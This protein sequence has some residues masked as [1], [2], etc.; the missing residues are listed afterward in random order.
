[1]ARTKKKPD[2]SGGVNIARSTV[3]VKGSV[4]GRDYKQTFIYINRTRGHDELQTLYDGRVQS[5][6]GYY[7]YLGAKDHPAPF[8]GRAADLDALDEWLHAKNAPPYALLVAPAGR[9]KSALL[10][11]WI[12]RISS[13]LS[14]KKS[15]VEIV[16]FPISSRFNTNLE[17]VVFASLA[18]RLA[19]LYGEKVTTTK[20]AW[21]YRGVFS[22]YLQRTPPK[23]KRIL[24]VVDGLDEAAGWEA[25]ADLFPTV[26][27]NHL[28][29]VVAARPLA[30]D[31]DEGAWLSR[32]GWNTPGKAKRLQ[33]TPLNLD[34]VRDVFMQMGDQLK[35]LK[36]KI[37]LARRLYELSQGDPLLVRLYIEALLPDNG[38]PPTFTLEDLSKQ[39]EREESVPGLKDYFDRWFEKIWGEAGEQDEAILDLFNLCAAAFG[40]LKKSDVLKLAPDKFNNRQKLE[41]A[42]HTVRRFII[43]DGMTSGYVFSHPRLGEYFLQQ[44]LDDE[45]KNFEERFLQYGRD[46]LANLENKTLLPKEVSA[47]VIQYYGAH[48]V[49]AKAPAANFYALI[50][51]GWL[52][53]W[54]W[55]GT[56]A[57]FLNDAER[58]WQKAEAEGPAALGQQIRAALCFASVTS[59]ST[60]ISKDLLMACVKAKVISPAFGLV[61]AREKLD[62]KD[63][64]ECLAAIAEFQPLAEFHAAI[65]EAWA[66]AHVISHEESRAQVLLEL[67]VRFPVS[68]LGEA[69]SIAGVI[70]DEWSRVRVWRVLALWL[71][72]SLLGI[73]LLAAR[74]IFDEEGR[75]YVLGT[76]A[77]RLPENLLGETFSA[78]RAINNG[79]CRAHVLGELAPRLPE[80]EQ[81]EVLGEALSVASAISDVRYRAKALWELAPRL[82]E[83]LLGEALSVARVISDEWYRAQVLG[84][85]VQRLPESLLEEVL[86][87]AR[88]ISDEAS[89]AEVLVA[90]A[91]RL[92][93]N[94]LGEALSAARAISNKETR[95]KTLMEITPRLLEHEQIGVWGEALSAARVISD[96]KSRAK[97]LEALVPRLPESLLGD[98]L[99]VARVISDQWYRA[100]VLGALAARLPEHEQA[101][102]LGE[103]LSAVRAIS[104]NGD[105]AKALMKIASR[106]PEHE[107]AKVS[108]E[109]LS[110]VRAIPNRKFRNSVLDALAP[111]LPESLS[112]KALSIAGLISDEVSRAS[113][114]IELGSRL[115]ECDHAEVLGEALMAALAVSYEEYR[116]AVLMALAPRLPKS[117]LDEALSAARAL[118]ID[119]RGDRARVLGELAPRLPEREQAEVLEEALSAARA[120]S[121]QESRAK[122]LGELAPHLPEHERAGVLR[123]VLSAAGAISD[124]WS[125]AD[126]LEALAPRLPESLLGEAL[127]AARAISHEEPRAR[128]LGVLAPRLPEREQAEVL[129]EALSAARAIFHEEPR[130]RVLGVLAP[131]LPERE[132]AEVFKE[133]LSV[134]RAISNEWS[135]AIVLGKLAPRLP[136]HEQAEVFKEALSA[137][138]AISDEKNRAEILW[139]LAPRLPDSLLGEALQM[140]R[141]LCHHDGSIAVL[142]SLAPRWSAVCR[143]TQRTELEELSATLRAFARTKRPQLLQA[144][145]ALL[146]VIAAQGGVPALRETAR[147]IV[148]TAKW[149]L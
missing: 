85:L 8:G 124:Q 114:L 143:S 63:R 6:L 91:P 90:L 149:W 29:I 126:F 108:G 144:I 1:M 147:A 78:A 65:G 53:A 86:S 50:C 70:S 16:Y 17:D 48:L 141:S 39:N 64:A 7:L 84:A 43:G 142:S 28:R 15:K 146:P 58:A 30:G 37:D 113:I 139:E 10:A 72:E 76:L 44:M 106:L 23:N 51:E 133:A 136:E 73:V 94:L 9:G 42:A 120:I 18:A 27:P 79:W 34:G 130:A 121:Y 96:E 56:P 115:P 3:H 71:P 62:P 24:V 107:Q 138:R 101:R 31:L 81:A 69:L 47:Y 98:A 26:P 19:H 21:E 66:A 95:V 75:A 112:G 4:V 33:L 20:S 67:V 89:C 105:R 11:H 110:A 137:A 131:R 99:S 45:R 118:S 103:A 13:Q 57:G 52:R 41:K 46:T 40:P 83:S 68:L 123:E 55:F 145:Q 49:R 14:R 35:A 148:D 140:A 129:G 128:V 2:Q 122:V 54:E 109:A 59:L 125:R 32:L 97:V 12:T 61:I 36:P 100:E 92:P 5:F 60:N 135:R 127:S 88:A 77:P 117:L 38:T 74:A 104:H 82:P 102:V 119:N 22:D 80:R 134:T 111:R 116:A 93:E 132:Q 87:A 25:G